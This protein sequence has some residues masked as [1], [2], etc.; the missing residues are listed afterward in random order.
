M[1]G[2]DGQKLPHVVPG[3]KQT[4]THAHVPVVCVLFSKGSGKMD[5]AAQSQLP[6][7]QRPRSTGALKKQ[8]LLEAQRT[9]PQP[10]LCAPSQ[11]QSAD[12]I[13]FIAH[14]VHFIHAC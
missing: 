5:T 14:V 11:Q 8:G 2:S 13:A 4:E 3:R 10:Q 6:R 12:D 1:M 9:A 7:S